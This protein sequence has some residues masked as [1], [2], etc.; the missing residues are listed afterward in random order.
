MIKG[1]KTKLAG[2]DDAMHKTHTRLISPEYRWYFSMWQRVREKFDQA[3][4]NRTWCNAK[5]KNKTKT[6]KN[7]TRLFSPKKVVYIYIF[8]LTIIIKGITLNFY[9]R[10][11]LKCRVEIVIGA[12]H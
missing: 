11:F 3:K 7:S 5:N 9:R 8:C 2:A 6:T 12:L 4:I 1:N 10:P